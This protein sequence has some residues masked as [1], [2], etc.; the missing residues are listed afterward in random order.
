LVAKTARRSAAAQPLIVLALPAT[1]RRINSVHAAEEHNLA[2][3][4]LKEEV[5]ET[6][7]FAGRRSDLLRRDHGKWRL[8]GREIL[9]EQNAPLAKNLTL[10]F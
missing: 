1:R 4:R 5:E 9:L 6:C 10:F 3:F 7:L 8:A 2:Y